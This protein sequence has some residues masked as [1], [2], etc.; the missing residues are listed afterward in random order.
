VPESSHDDLFGHDGRGYSDYVVSFLR[1]HLMRPPMVTEGRGETD[2]AKGFFSQGLV[3]LFETAPSLDELANA[4]APRPVVKRMDAARLWPFGG[5][6]LLTPFR[7][8]VNGYV[9]I[10]VVDREWPDDM[11]DPKDDTGVFGAWSMGHFGP[12]TF[13]R[14]LLRAGQQSWH[15]RGAAADAGRHRAFVR[16]RSSYVF[17]ARGNAPVLPA[18]YAPLPELLFVT[19]I[20]EA[21]LAIA[22]ALCYF[23]PNGECLYRRDSVSSL[24]ARHKESGPVAQELWCNVRMFQL[25]ADASWLLMD[26]V[27]M[28]QLDAPDHEACFPKDRYE[29][30]EVAGFLRSAADY[31]CE[32][33]PV[34]Q[35][36]DT[37]DG[38]GGIRW[39]GARFENGLA[40]PPRKVLR[41]LPL[42]G[43]RRPPGIQGEA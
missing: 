4:I 26:T 43:L 10:D 42:D 17:G 7:S 2:M 31:A 39:Q 11:G 22:S 18:D 6:S 24:L 27:G 36:G 35:N 20:A 29:A 3:V 28:A 33:G 21:I 32:R 38:P 23:N 40:D 12:H 5:P 9:A 14:A 13:P 41:W 16:A 25:P 15:W 19:E 8:D 1:R 30:R 34:I 37:M